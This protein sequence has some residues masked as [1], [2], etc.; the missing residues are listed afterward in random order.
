MITSVASGQP[1]GAPPSSFTRATPEAG[2][3]TDGEVHQVGEHAAGVPAIAVGGDR[4][5]ATCLGK[6]SL[7]RGPGSVGSVG[8][9]RNELGSDLDT[10]VGNTAAAT[11]ASRRSPIRTAND[12]KNDRRKL[13]VRRRPNESIFAPWRR[14][15]PLAWT[16][17]EANNV[18]TAS[19]S[20]PKPKTVVKP[21]PFDHTAEQPFA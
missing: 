3:R 12:S 5:E 15:A 8:E 7:G 17:N 6:R 16:S 9:G 18:S 13:L 2:T 21:S 20:G 14:K 10:R 1:I 11:V 19:S 4:G